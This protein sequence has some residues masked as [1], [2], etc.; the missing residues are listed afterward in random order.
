MNLFSEYDYEASGIVQSNFIPLSSVT[1]IIAHINI[2]Q[3]VRT[4]FDTLCKLLLL[5]VYCL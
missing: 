5:W 3:V 4:L 1:G 2:T